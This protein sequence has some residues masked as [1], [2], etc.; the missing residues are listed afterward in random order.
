MYK[1]QQSSGWRKWEVEEWN[2]KWAPILPLSLCACMFRWRLHEGLHNVYHTSWTL[3]ALYARSVL[4]SA[5]SVLESHPSAASLYS[6]LLS[7]ISVHLC[8]RILEEKGLAVQLCV[9]RVS[10]FQAVFK[11]FVFSA[12]GIPFTSQITKPKCL[13]AADLQS[14]LT[15]HRSALNVN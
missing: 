7:W 1:Q 2:R 6:P 9:L 14:V 11:W 4:V 5:C 10:S 8:S 12:R 3:F 13:K 15:R